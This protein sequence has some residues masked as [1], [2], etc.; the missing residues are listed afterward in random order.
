MNSAQ[1]I[2]RASP[3][4]SEHSPPQ[5]CPPGLSRHLLS[6]L[7][8]IAVAV[9]FFVPF[10]WLIITSLKQA[11]RSLPIRSIWIPRSDHVEQLS[12]CSHHPRL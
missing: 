12:R 8:L 11:T 6:H 3:E 4:M 5:G 7:V 1:A 10:I 9:L 2:L